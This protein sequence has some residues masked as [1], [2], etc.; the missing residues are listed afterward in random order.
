MGARPCPETPRA[1]F[2]AAGDT[3]SNEI[4]H[5]GRLLAELRDGRMVA[6]RNGAP[7]DLFVSVAAGASAEHVTEGDS[8]GET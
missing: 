4:G 2:Q 7:L 8:D 6:S 3:G 5:A 1:G